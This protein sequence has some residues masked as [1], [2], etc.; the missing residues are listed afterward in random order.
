MLARFMGSF[1]PPKN[2]ILYVYALFPLPICRWKWHAS[3]QLFAQS[4]SFEEEVCYAQLMNKD[5]A[6]LGTTMQDSE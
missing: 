6:D 1:L 2:E 3:R 4:L 5:Y